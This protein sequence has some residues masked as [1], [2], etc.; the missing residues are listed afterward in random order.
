MLCYV[1]FIFYFLFFFIYLFIFFFFFQIEKLHRLLSTFGI[2]GV[3][4][5]SVEEFQG[6]E[7]MV[8]LISTVRSSSGGIEVNILNNLSINEYFSNIL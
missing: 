5:G 6:Q 7:R 4:V 2:E 3:K 8:I 1:Y